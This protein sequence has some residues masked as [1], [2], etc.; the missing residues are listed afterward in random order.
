MTNTGGDYT[1]IDNWARIPE[2]PSGRTNGRTH[3]VCVTA[4]GRVMVFHQAHDG[5]LT[6]DPQGRLRAAV[7]GDRWLGA[8]GLTLVSDTDGEYLWLT[9][10]STAEVVKVTLEGQ[11]VQ[12]I[13]RAPHPVYA[14]GGR[15]CPTWAAQNPVTGEIWVADGYGSSLVHRYSAGGDYQA[16]L[17]G[18]EGAGRFNCPHG[19]NFRTTANGP[20]LWITDRGNRRVVVTDGEGQFLR[21]TGITHSPCCFDFHQ[22]LVVIPELFTGVK[23]LQADTL[24]LVTELGASD[25]VSPDAKPDGWPNL[26]GTDLVKPGQFNSPHGGCFAPNGDIF[27]VEW[28]VGGRITRLKRNT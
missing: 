5:L 8:H 7:G 12:T 17:D 3:G 21:Q 19:I 25:C 24:E 11:T 2:H 9:D 16:T 28:I 1:W 23:V 14:E 6:F 4:D 22:D 10:Q 18:S 26:A 13:E 20:E 15:Y 27:C